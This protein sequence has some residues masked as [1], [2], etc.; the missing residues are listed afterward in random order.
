MMSFLLKTVAAPHPL[1][2][3]SPAV[4]ISLKM[5]IFSCENLF[6][7]FPTNVSEIF[8]KLMS[9][10]SPCSDKSRITYSDLKLNK[11]VFYWLQKALQKPVFYKTETWHS[12]AGES[13][14]KL[15]INVQTLQQTNPVHKPCRP[16]WSHVLRVCSSA[17]LELFNFIFIVGS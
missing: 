17:D 13:E 12:Y 5:V 7:N 6:S 11:A 10:Q 9:N 8:Q 14:R 3:Q 2:G 4:F 16:R 15:G 1:T